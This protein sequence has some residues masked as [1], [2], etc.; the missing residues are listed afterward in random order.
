MIKAKDYQL[1]WISV[2]YEGFMVPKVI[3]IPEGT[4]LTQPLFVATPSIGASSSQLVLQEEEEE[5]EE[6]EENPKGI[7]TLSESLEEFKVFN[8]PPSSEDISADIDSQ[9][10]VDITTFDEMGIQ[11][12]NQRSLMDLIESQPER[13]ALGK[14]AKPKLPPPPPKSPLPPPQPPQPARP[15]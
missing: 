4:P 5:E 2:A 14:F 7:V 9:Q 12:K 11:R 1:H 13:D 6:E 10:Q 15:D 3:L 8:Q